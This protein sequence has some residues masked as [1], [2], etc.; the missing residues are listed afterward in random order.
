MPA[1]ARKQ[2][3]PPTPGELLDLIAQRKAE[4]PE[5][6]RKQNDAAEQSVVSGDDAG[7]MAA[8][9]AVAALHR[10]VERLQSAM[11]GATARS[12]EAAEAQQRAAQAALRQHI[13]ELLEQRL[14]VAERIE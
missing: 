1:P 7:Y 11:V 14:P 12:R 2:T 6:L 4:L 9:A 3:S 8:V 10:E 5:L 13:S